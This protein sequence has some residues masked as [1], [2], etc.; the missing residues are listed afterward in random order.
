MEI[1]NNVFLEIDDNVCGYPSSDAHYSPNVAYL[2]YPWQ[3]EVS[4]EANL[5]YDMVRNILIRAGL[6]RQNYQSTIWNPLG[7]YISKGNTVLIKPNWV[8]DK[9]KN[10]NAGK[11]GLECLVTHPSVVRAV[12]DYVIIALQGTGR[13]ILAD[14][15]MQSCNLERLFLNTGYKKLFEFYREKGISIEVFD[16]RKYSVDVKTKGVYAVPNKNENG[17]KSVKIN[18]EKD[19]MHSDNDMQKPRYKV[20]DYEQI[21]TASYHSNG[22][23]IYEVNELVLQADVIINLPKPK[24]H[25]LAGFTGACKNVVGIVY[26]KACLPHR[27]EGDIESKSGD[28]YQKASTWKLKMARW[29]ELRTRYSL[30]GRTFRSKF[31][32]VLMKCCYVVGSLTTG[33]FYRI[34]SWYGNDTIWRTVI[35]L[36]RILL[37]ADQEGRMRE[38]PQRKIIVIGDMIISGERNGPVAPSPKM[39]GMLMFSDNHLAFDRVLCEI[40]GFDVSVFQ[41]FSDGKALSV[42]GYQSAKELNATRVFG[43]GFH[44]ISINDFP[45]MEKWHFRPHDCWIGHIEKQRMG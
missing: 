45:C 19:S 44:G 2:E 26:D 23:H 9:N 37:Y 21:L 5:I 6:D 42:F 4:K 28:A 16:L 34:G 3:N 7:A 36:N 33:D 27:I 20:E 31:C 13:I 32:D 25:R 15:P 38:R 18:L 14:A 1:E 39:M 40:M 24:T 35:D 41:M 22:K 8:D 12:I 10:K 17:L 43:G 30:A 29:N 11:K